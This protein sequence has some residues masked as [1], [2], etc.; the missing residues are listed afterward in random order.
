M[1]VPSQRTLITDSMSLKAKREKENHWH[2]TGFPL[3][4]Y[5][6]FSQT[7]IHRN[8]FSFSS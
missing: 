7:G 1:T 3:P 6:T 4:L 5:F 8:L 2:S